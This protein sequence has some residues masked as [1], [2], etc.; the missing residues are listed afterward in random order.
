M[1]DR[2]EEGHGEQFAQSG[3]QVVMAKAVDSVS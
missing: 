3:G 2:T 1:V